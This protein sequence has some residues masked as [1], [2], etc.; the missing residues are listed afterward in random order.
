[1]PP[2]AGVGVAAG[3]WLPPAETVDEASAPAIAAIG[4]G[5]NLGDA[6]ATVRAA[7]DELGTIP[8]SRL[9][10]ASP[11]YRSA[12]WGV[13]NQPDFIN[14]VALVETTLAPRALLEALLEIERRHGRDRR[15]EIR[16]GPRTLDLDLLLHG[17]AV[18]DEDGLTLPHP[19]MH[20]RAFVLRPLLDVWPD[21]AIPGI[22]PADLALTDLQPAGIARIEG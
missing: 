13:K 21:V 17:D 8:D 4:L 16:W 5:A 11:L 14:A 19:Q 18:L 22:G 20:R 10:R 15:N 9:L 1:M 7:I 2:H 12:A 3:Q 6:I